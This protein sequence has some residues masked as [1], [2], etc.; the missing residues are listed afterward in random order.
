[1]VH[2]FKATNSAKRMAI[3]SALVKE[4]HNIVETLKEY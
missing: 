1:M 2:P 4:G 3:S